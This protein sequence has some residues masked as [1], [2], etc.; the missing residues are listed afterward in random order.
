MYRPLINTFG[1]AFD[2]R[3]VIPEFT[4]P[5]AYHVINVPPLM[6]QLQ[7]FTDETLIMIFYT[8]PKDV[9]QE[10][11]ANA[12]FKRDWRWHTELRQF[13]QKDATN[14]QQPTRISDKE[15]RGYYIFFDVNSWRRERR[16]FVLNYDHMYP[17]FGVTA[18]PIARHVGPQQQ[19]PISQ[20]AAHFQT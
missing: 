12:L 13:M 1:S 20:F 16:E 15:E 6:N 17:K 19:L 3:P 2:D 8:M 9:L 14:A 4:V 18:P 10:H 7:S 11:A 5:P